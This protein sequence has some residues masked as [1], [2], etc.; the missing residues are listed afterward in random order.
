MKA[1]I[2]SPDARAIGSLAR[3]PIKIVITPALSAVA[4]N[5][6]GYAIPA[7]AIIPGWTARM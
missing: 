7:A 2:P 4:A 6:C 1:F 5:T 3:T